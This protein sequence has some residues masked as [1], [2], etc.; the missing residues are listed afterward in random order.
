MV[1]RHN[2]EDL[3]DEEEKIL[4]E[5][6]ALI[7]AALIAQGFRKKPATDRN[8]ASPKDDS[9]RTQRTVRQGD[10]RFYDVL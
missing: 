4:L 10:A 5:E 3:D 9:S 1:E 6:G 7:A 8:S 2:E